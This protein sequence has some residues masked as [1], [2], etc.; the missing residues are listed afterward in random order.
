MLRLLKAVLIGALVWS[1]Y[2]A[3]AGWMMQSGVARWFAAQ[4]ARGWQA[5]YADLSLGGFPARH[6]T[7]ITA[8]AL[9]DPAT[10]AA[11]RAEALEIDSRAIWPGHVTVGLGDAPQLWS[12]FDETWRVTTS[13]LTADLRLTPGLALTVEDLSLRSGAWSVVAEDGVLARA[14]TLVLSKTQ[15]SDGPATYR[16]IARAEAFAPGARLR[17][18]ARSS[19]TLPEAF[20]TLEIDATVTYDN[21]WDRS[22]LEIARPQP[23]R[24]D[25][26]LAEAEWGALRLAAAGDFV[27]DDQGIP[28]GTITIKAENWRE[29]LDMAEAAGVLPPEARRPAERTLAL[30]EGL[31][32]NPNAL[33]LQ[34][35]LRGG[36]VAL[37]PIPLGPAPRLILR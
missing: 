19:R 12:Y 29:M 35:N 13:G 6:V 4:E 18:I 22:A 26:R 14:E 11:W 15:Q 2:W 9:A 23:K 28:E 1:I 21:P 17:E 25:L 20:E 27:V 16:M 7:R 3:G 33:D 32:G 10:G 5:D 36:F 30:F 34:L 37:G 8:P 24:V 31:S